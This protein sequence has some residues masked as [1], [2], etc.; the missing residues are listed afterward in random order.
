MGPILAMFKLQTPVSPRGSNSKVRV[1]SLAIF[2]T[3]FD[4]LAPALLLGLGLA[5]AA[6]LAVVGA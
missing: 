6:A 1:M 4:R 5:S 3:L 2:D